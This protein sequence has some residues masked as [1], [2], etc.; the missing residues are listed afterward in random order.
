MEVLVLNL[1]PGCSVG[2]DVQMQWVEHWRG[3]RCVFPAL[4]LSET[5]GLSLYPLCASLSHP[6]Y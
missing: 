5:I 6:T 2:H 1:T 3:A 4:L